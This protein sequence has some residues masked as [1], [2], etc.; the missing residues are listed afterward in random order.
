MRCDKVDFFQLGK[1]INTKNAPRPS[2]PLDENQAYLGSITISGIHNLVSMDLSDDGT[3]LAVSDASSL[4]IFA[5]KFVDDESN[6]VCMRKVIV[7]TKINLPLSASAPSSSLKFVPD[8]SQR[9][10][11]A[12][13]TGVVTVLK[14]KEQHNVDYKVTV[15]HI[16][17]ELVPDS[18]MPAY[19]FP[20]T[21]IVINPDCSFIAL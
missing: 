13:T 11:C 4:Y 1:K 16:F 17:N 8:G 14:I 19:N 15:E 20:I 3:L 12:S 7:P 18:K 2:I 6:N 10:I 5:L 21:D 9:L